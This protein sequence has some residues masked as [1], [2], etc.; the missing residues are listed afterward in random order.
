MRHKVR[1]REIRRSLPGIFGAICIHL[2]PECYMLCQ[3]Q[4]KRTRMKT[5]QQSRFSGMFIWQQANLRY[6]NRPNQEGSSAE[7]QHKNTSTQG[8]KQRLFLHSCWCSDTLN[9]KVWGSIRVSWIQRAGRTLPLPVSLLPGGLQ[10]VNT[11]W[12][13][14]RY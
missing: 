1:G 9:L 13:H 11:L 12:H 4:S 8:P 2:H 14:T 5:P 3:K 10:D 6:W 7:Q